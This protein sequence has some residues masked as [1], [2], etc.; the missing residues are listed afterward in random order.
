MYQIDV[1]SAVAALPAPAALG[2]P[3]Y[4]TDG[5]VA[6]GVPP[7]VVT[8]DWLNAV[9]LELVNVV[10]AGGLAPSKV[11]TNQLLLAIQALIE[12]RSGNYAIDTGG[13]GTYVVALNPVVA[14]YT[15][16]LQ[17]RFRATHAN[18]GPATLDAGAGPA[19]LTRDDGTP[20]QQGDVPLNSVVSA[21]YDK[22]ANIFLLN[23]VVPSQLGGVASLNIGAF[24]KNDGNGNLA[25][26]NGTFL[27]ADGG[28]N[29]AVQIGS[30]LQNDGAGNIR[31]KSS[32]Q[33]GTFS[34][35]QVFA[36]NPNGHVAGNAGV[37]GTSAP[38]SCWDVTNNL[39]Y[40]C[41]A[42]GTAATAVWQQ[43]TP[44]TFGAAK[45]TYIN[46]NAAVGPGGYLVDTSAGPVTVTL[47]G[48]PSL[49]DNYT[50]FDAAGTWSPNNLTINRNGN[51]MMGLA[52][53][54]V[55]N[56]SGASLPGESLCI[57]F[58]GITWR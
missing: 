43:Q 28:G 51:P 7:T 24:L 5:S 55:C 39:L 52:E 54:L 37:A 16:G 47:T 12:A 2:T 1:P 26:K 42:T 49:G 56:V 13:A 50:F 36:G 57:W 27:A 14:A 38:S 18:G 41:S 45:L 6:G 44:S 32:D 8:A 33:L 17:V 53:N 46:S 30:G 9:M 40:I 4:F 19:P 31:V 20:L 15:N 25:V 10:A 21:T 3:G 29:L 23:S 22:P 34:A 58:N 48:S 11:A 35:T